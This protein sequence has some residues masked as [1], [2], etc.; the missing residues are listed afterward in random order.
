[1]SSGERKRNSY[2]FWSGTIEWLER[3]ILNPF[4]YGH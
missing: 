1:V 3:V 2:V 4:F